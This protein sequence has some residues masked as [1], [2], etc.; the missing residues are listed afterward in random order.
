MARPKAASVLKLS[1]MEINATFA[2]IMISSIKCKVSF[3]LQLGRSSSTTI[4]WVTVPASMFS[5]IPFMPG[6]SRLPFE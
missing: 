2:E 1:R 4:T 6:R 3:W 5:I